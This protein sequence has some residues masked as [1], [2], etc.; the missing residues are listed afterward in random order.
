MIPCNIVSLEKQ[1]HNIIAVLEIDTTGAGAV[2]YTIDPQD[3]ASEEEYN[4]AVESN[5]VKESLIY[6]I[7]HDALNLRLGNAVLRQPEA[8]S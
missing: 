2:E 8:G 3:F 7:R 1:G 5:Q 6:R 4:Q